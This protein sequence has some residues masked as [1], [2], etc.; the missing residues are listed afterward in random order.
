MTCRAGFLGVFLWGDAVWVKTVRGETV[1]WDD[2]VVTQ[3]VS[4]VTYLVK[5]SQA[6]R[7]TIADHIR[8]RYASPDFSSCTQLQPA[9]QPSQDSTLPRVPRPCG[10]VI[11]SPLGVPRATESATA[12][13][14]ATAS[15]TAGT[16]AS[17]SPATASPSPDQ[18]G[19]V[20]APSAAELPTLRRSERVRHAPNRYQSSD[21]RK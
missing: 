21:F 1:S 9:F 11:G 14:P 3:V 15:H 19:A 10:P 17:G 6:V 12:S 13:L 4:P 7:F 18:P 16:A 5:V 2:G 8:A 20:G